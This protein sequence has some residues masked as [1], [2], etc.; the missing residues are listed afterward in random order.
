MSQDEAFMK[1]AL[2][3]AEKG[4]G[5]TSPN[6]MVGAVIVK[7]GTVVGEG[8]HERA[9]EPH[10]EVHALRQAGDAARGATLYVTLEPCSHWGRTGPCAE[11]VIQAGI[12]RVVMAVRDPNPKVAGR[13][14][15]LL[16]EAGV[17]VE[18][19]L[20]AEEAVRLN[21]IFFHWITKK[22]PFCLAKYAMSMD[23]KIATATGE[24]KWIS[25][26]A[27][28]Q[29]VQV[30]RHALDG[31][32]VGVDTVIADDPALTCRLPGGRQPLRI[33]LDS[34]GRTPVNAHV[35]AVADAKTLIAT[36]SDG[37]KK[38]QT[39]LAGRP[40][41]SV[42]VLPADDMGR[43]SL[44]DLLTMLGEHSVTSLL[45][46]GGAGVLGSFFA[47]E[48][49]DKVQLF[50]APLIIGGKESPG[51]VGGVGSAQLVLAPRFVIDDCRAVG[52]DLLITA[53]P[54]TN[55]GNGATCSQ[56]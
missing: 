18:E 23:G 38:L 56:G 4:R 5:T 28:R 29:Q 21:E 37:E 52:G 49:I 19:G 20:L 50:L 51:P 35:V 30:L 7:D 10:A 27:S 14:A 6:P 17:L 1:R 32:L 31:I 43:V 53:Y 2:Q 11:A 55:E 25:S 8:W 24:S 45:V 39:V 41:I 26:E 9:G 33:I 22:R 44:P 42:C 46:E 16:R 15:A 36:T 13:G 54:K 3:L 34:R 12:S 40:H 48:L 47:E